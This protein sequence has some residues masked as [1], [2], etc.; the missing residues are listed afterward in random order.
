MPQG[1]SSHNEHQNSEHNELPN[2]HLKELKMLITLWKEE[3]GVREE[4][5]AIFFK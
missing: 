1:H 5:S 4:V 2:N 3:M